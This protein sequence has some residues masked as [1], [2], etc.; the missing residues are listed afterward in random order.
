MKADIT[1]LTE[2]Q[3][4]HI[5]GLLEEEGFEYDEHYTTLY[6]AK[7]SVI[8]LQF[9]HPHALWLAAGLLSRQNCAHI[10]HAVGRS[11]PTIIC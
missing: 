11:V 3:V 8:G 5:C 7:W 4:T 9:T 2:D 10:L 6:G 1:G